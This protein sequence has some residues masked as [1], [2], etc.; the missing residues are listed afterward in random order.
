MLRL[1]PQAGAGGEPPRASVSGSKIGAEKSR[2]LDRVCVKHDISLYVLCFCHS[3]KNY[4]TQDEILCLRLMPEF[5]GQDVGKGG[6][7]GHIIKYG[8]FCLADL[9]KARY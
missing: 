2:C 6:K 8:K 9:G 7:W 3:K 5:A 4:P 1:E